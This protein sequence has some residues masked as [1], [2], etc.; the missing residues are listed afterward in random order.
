MIAFMFMSIM[1][2]TSQKQA[3]AILR[4]ETMDTRQL[5]NRASTTGDSGKASETTLAKGLTDGICQ[6]Y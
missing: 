3:R 1:L 6:F 2:S 5:N 4:N